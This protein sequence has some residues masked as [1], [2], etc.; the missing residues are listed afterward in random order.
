MPGAP[1]EYEHGA[2][3]LEDRPDLTEPDIIHTGD[4]SDEPR[5]PY[6]LTEAEDAPPSGDFED[7]TTL[8]PPD[9]VR[10]KETAAAIERNRPL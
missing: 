7:S 10:D 1:A 6:G 2:R 8:P 4:R 5:K 9:P 3:K